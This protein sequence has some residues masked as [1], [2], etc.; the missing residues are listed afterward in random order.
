ME[1]GTPGIKS[2]PDGWLNRYLAE[3]KNAESPFRGVALTVQLPRMLCR[4]R[5]GFDLVFHR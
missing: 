2:T 3:K 5:V 4:Q 1:I